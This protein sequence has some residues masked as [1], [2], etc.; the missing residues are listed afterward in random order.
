MEDADALTRVINETYL[1]KHD[2]NINEE[3][4]D[5]VNEASFFNR[6]WRENNVKLIKVNGDKQLRWR[7]EE[8]I[9]QK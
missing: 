2:E 3:K 4:E 1:P 7:E 8:T 5:V 6:R 9:M